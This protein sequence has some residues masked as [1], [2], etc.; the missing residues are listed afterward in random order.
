MLWVYAENDSFFGPPIASM[1]YQSFS[2]AGGKADFEQVG[3]YGPD[4]HGLFGER[5]GVA[6]W[7]SLVERY[8]SRQLASGG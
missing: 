7:G 1:L 8:L 2:V 3:R 5:G 6:I 4:G